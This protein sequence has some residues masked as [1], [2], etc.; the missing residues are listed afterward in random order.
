MKRILKAS[1]I[2]GSFGSINIQ[3]RRRYSFEQSHFHAGVQAHEFQT[4]KRAPVDLPMKWM[5]V[6][7]PILLNE[8]I[9]I[10]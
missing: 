1:L 10:L 2:D 9:N 8:L 6:P 5:M 4:P 3:W 7:H